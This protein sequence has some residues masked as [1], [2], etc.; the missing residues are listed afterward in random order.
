MDADRAPA[1]PARAAP[2]TE[3]PRRPS[4]T[5]NQ[6]AAAPSNRIDKSTSNAAV[7]PG[8]GRRS[9]VAVPQSAVGNPV[10]PRPAPPSAEER[11]ASTTGATPENADSVS[12]AW[13]VTSQVE[14]ATIAAYKD[15]MLG[16]RLDLEHVGN[17]VVGEGHKVSENGAP[18]PQRRRTPIK[19]EGTLEGNRLVLDFT[20]VGARRTSAGHFLLYLSE[21]GSFRGRFQSDAAQSSGV[22]VA[23]RASSSGRQ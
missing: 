13:N 9:E 5:R 11:A 3:L 12:G 4:D 21:D 15:L 8:T 22:T 2:D 20:E 1:Q 14:S 7:R 18:L 19:V 10:M 16:F 17:R 23:V 6:T